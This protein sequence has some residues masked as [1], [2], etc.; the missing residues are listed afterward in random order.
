MS[1]QQWVY[2]KLINMA[3]LTA[4][5][6][7]VRI[8]ASGSIGSPPAARPFM[9]VRYLPSTIEIRDNGSVR[10]FKE[11]VQFWVYDEEGSYSLINEILDVVEDNFP[12]PVEGEPTIGHIDWN[13]LGP[14]QFDDDL[15]ALVRWGSATIVG[16]KP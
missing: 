10:S 16:S 7:A 3:P 11:I 13:G 6:P 9:Q 8:V 15:K 1:R 12:G 14:E 4:L 5:L 2:E